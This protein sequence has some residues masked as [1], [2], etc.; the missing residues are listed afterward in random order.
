MYDICVGNVLRGLGGCRS[1][2][3]TFIHV[4]TCVCAYA[5]LYRASTD[6]LHMHSHG[7]GEYSV[8]AAEFLPGSNAA[9]QVHN[10]IGHHYIGHNYI[11][12]NYIG[13]HYIGHNYIGHNYMGHHY[14]G[15]RSYRK[16][17]FVDGCL[18]PFL[19]D[20]GVTIQAMTTWAIPT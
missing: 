16:I 8:D 6:F 7:Y 2:G 5:R 20:S 4:K 15:Q 9:V 14:I 11:G 3:S 18:D 17:N 19:A 10:Y 1:W 12:H 13:H